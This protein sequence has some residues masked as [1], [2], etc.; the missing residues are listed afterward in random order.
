MEQEPET[1]ARALIGQY[2]ERL[3]RDE[4]AE[5]AIAV[6]KMA[7]WYVNQMEGIKHT[8]QSLAE[9]DLAQRGLDSLHTPIGSAGWTEPR[10]RQ[11]DEQS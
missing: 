4:D 2:S 5:T 7:N 3:A 8:A 9:Q 6:Y 10:A 1:T 11:L